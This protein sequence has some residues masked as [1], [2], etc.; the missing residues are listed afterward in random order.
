[1]LGFL[2]WMHHLDTDLQITAAMPY[3]PFLRFGMGKAAPLDECCC[4]VWLWWSL[5]IL[6]FRAM[7]WLPY[8][9]AEEVQG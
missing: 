4:T 1:M 7:V 2:M 6:S 5:S 3:K 8:L 9:C